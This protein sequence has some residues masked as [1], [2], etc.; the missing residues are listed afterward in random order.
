ME[1][2]IK[3]TQF[4]LRKQNLTKSIEVQIYQTPPRQSA[5]SKK[6]WGGQN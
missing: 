5:I 3:E 2:K 6:N 4:S 1:K